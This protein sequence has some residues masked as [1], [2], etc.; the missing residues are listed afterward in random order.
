MTQAR[1]FKAPG[2][3]S[4]VGRQRGSVGHGLGS[5]G[6]CAGTAGVIITGAADCQSYY[7]IILMFGHILAQVTF[8]SGCCGRTEQLQYVEA[9]MLILL[10]A[11]T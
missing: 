1:I 4:S 6:F 2:Q 8:S 5:V 9:Q 10:I 3:K 7:Y 11:P